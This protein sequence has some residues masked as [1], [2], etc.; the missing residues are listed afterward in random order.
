MPL[1]LGSLRRWTEIGNIGTN[2]PAL[3]NPLMTTIQFFRN[4]RS[5]L[6]ERRCHE[7]QYRNTIRL[8]ETHRTTIIKRRTRWR[9]IDSSDVYDEN[10]F[11][12][13]DITMDAWILRRYRISQK[14]HCK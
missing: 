7:R 13:S 10:V 11:I 4:Q 1:T 6:V 2:L 5:I 14:C 12:V 8:I 3:N 9:V